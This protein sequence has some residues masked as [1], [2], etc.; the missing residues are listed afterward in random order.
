MSRLETI[1]S[2][3]GG[4]GSEFCGMPSNKKQSSCHMR[5]GLNHDKKQM[6]NMPFPLLAFMPN[7][8]KFLNVFC[9]FVAI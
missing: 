3:I 2:I 5:F 8:V 7:D 1:M 9:F 6:C 4:R